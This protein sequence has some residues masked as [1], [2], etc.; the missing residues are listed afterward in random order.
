VKQEE[1]RLTFPC[2]R[3]FASMSPA[4]GGRLC[5]ECHTVVR[6]LSSMSER[7]ARALLESAG[8]S[9]LCVRY[10]YDGA[11]HVRFAGDPDVAEARIVP[12]FRLSARRRAQAARLALVAAPFVLFEACGGAPGLG[13]PQQN[14]EPSGLTVDDGSADDGPAETGVAPTQE[15]PDGGAD[16]Q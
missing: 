14:W 3:D 5:A 6:D 10:L 12:A 16:E 9:R 11:G 13:S 7:D 15:Q 8:P 2:G 1:V 4:A